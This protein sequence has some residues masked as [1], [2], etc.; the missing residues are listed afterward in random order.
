MIL[1]FH[2]I[3]VIGGVSAWY[4][5]GVGFE[6]GFVTEIESE[7]WMPSPINK[8]NTLHNKVLQTRVVQSKC[9]LFICLINWLTTNVP[10]KPNLLYFTSI[11]LSVKFILLSVSCKHFESHT[12]TCN[13]YSSHIFPI[14]YRIRKVQEVGEGMFH[15][16]PPPKKAWKSYFLENSGAYEYIRIPDRFQ[17][18]KGNILFKNKN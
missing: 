12:H 17:L 3:S 2:R 16:P 13:N 9:W 15:P 11:A 10:W 5:G 1:I 14:V 6:A 8:C 7:G 4:R 18:S